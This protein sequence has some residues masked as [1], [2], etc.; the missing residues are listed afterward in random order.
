[1][2]RGGVFVIDV[3]RGVFIEANMNLYVAHFS[4]SAISQF[5][6]NPGR[7]VSDAARIRHVRRGD[8]LLL[9]FQSLCDSSVSPTSGLRFGIEGTS[10]RV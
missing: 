5:A 10:S 8:L 4:L 1:M 2:Y 3:S 9:W 7:C 6:G